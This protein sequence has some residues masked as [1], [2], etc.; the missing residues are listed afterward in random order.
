MMT[1]EIISIG[2]EL[3]NGK[4]VNTNATYIAQQLYKIGVAISW[5]QTIGDDAEAIRQALKLALQRAD[6]VLVTGGLGP[7]HDDITKKTVAEFFNKR[8]VFREDL[9]EKVRER[10]ARRGIKMPEINRNQA[11]VP[12]DVRLMDN[13]VGTALGMIFEKEGKFTFVMPGVPREMQAMLE[14]SVIPFLRERCQE[15]RVE[16]NLFRTTGIPES[17]IYERIEKDL[18]DFS[19]YEIAFLPKFTGVDVRVIRRGRDIT[20]QEKFER[21]TRMLYEKIGNFIYTTEDKELEEVV[22]ELLREQQKTISVAESCTGGLVQ[23]KITDVPGSSDYFM[24]GMV[25]YSNEAKMKFLG[26][27]DESLRQYGAVS[28]VVAKEMAAG[29]RQAVGT[30][31]AVS[32]TGIAGPTGA[33]PTKPVGLVYVGLASADRVMARKFL[34]GNDRRINKERAAQAALDLVRRYLQGL[35]LE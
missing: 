9:L 29:V 26:V 15:C 27:K 10:F 8:L 18:P 28:E 13:P 3:L 14:D 31:I 33:T 30:D 21:F 24:G 35:P 22:G 16:V 5:I 17:S 20:D 12:E 4:T 32:T 1:A 11:L 23:D 7:T 19:S 6:V 34:F 25:T 2:N